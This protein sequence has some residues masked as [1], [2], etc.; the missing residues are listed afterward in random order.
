MGPHSLLVEFTH[1][2]SWNL[3]FVCMSHVFDLCL[4]QPAIQLTEFH[5]FVCFLERFFTCFKDKVVF[6]MHHI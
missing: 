3:I 6:E 5:S 4:F 2:R 1:S